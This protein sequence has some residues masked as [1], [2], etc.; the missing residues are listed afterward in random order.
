MLVVGALSGDWVFELEGGVKF[1]E[2]VKVT[3]VDKSGVAVEVVPEM[4][5]DGWVGVRK[6]VRVD[7]S[8]TE[9]ETV[10]SGIEDVVEPGKV[11]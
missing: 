9:M 6:A 3:V 10:L 11:T 7:V 5:G 8:M 4:S 2:G 1:I